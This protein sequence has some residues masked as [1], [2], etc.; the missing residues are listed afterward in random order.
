VEAYK[1]LAITSPEMNLKFVYSSRGDTADIGESVRAR[2][3]QITHAADGFFSNANVTFA[4]LGAKELIERYRETKQF[5][6]EIPFQDHLAGTGEG[7]IVVVKL[8]DYYRFVCDEKGNLRRYLF[9]SNVRDYLGENKVNE[10]IATSLKTELVPDFWWL[11]N[12]ITILTTKAVIN[13]KNMMMQDIQVVNG[14]QTTE[15]IYRHFGSGSRKSLD[16]TLSIKIIV[17]QDEKLRDQ[18]IRATNNQS[19]I[20]QSALHATD[21]I[22][23]DIEQ[24]LERH[25]FYYE[26]RKN[27]YRNIGQ[28]PA[29]FVTPLFVAAGFIAIVLKDPATAAELKS[30]FMR[31]QSNYDKVF[32]DKTP[33][34]VWP[35][36]VAIL[37]A[38]DSEMLLAPRHH[39]RHGERTLRY[40]RGLIGILFA[41]KS[42]GTFDFT[43]TDIVGIE[44]GNINGAL[45]SDCW[46]F[47]KVLRKGSRSPGNERSLR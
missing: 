45:V 24:I 38:A 26:R 5:T 47:I 37:K 22:Q 20:E 35:R 8:G 32:S 23:R 31:N 33:I 19:A 15:T 42:F 46:K 29:R 6:L 41:A 13:G 9:D 2:S 17:S 1:R 30:R 27:Y 11:N 10:D 44:V 12:G 28:P 4:F 7:Y 21:K 39:V 40:W 18:I 34:E 36:I 3:E 16:R 14:L 43:L 25:E